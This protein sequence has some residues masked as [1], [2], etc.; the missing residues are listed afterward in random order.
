MPIPV[1]FELPRYGTDL[2]AKADV[3]KKQWYGR[4]FLPAVLKY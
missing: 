4:V 3:S 1:Y 2:V